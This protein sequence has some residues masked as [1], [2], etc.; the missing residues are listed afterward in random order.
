MQKVQL[1]TWSASLKKIDVAIP[2]KALELKKDRGLFWRMLIL[3][4]LALIS[5]FRSA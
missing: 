1:Q 4:T 3:E 2:E 5:I